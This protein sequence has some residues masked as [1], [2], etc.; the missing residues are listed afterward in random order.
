MATSGQK[1]VESL[2]IF[3]RAK[4]G[5]FAV[6]GQPAKVD[7][8]PV[9]SD[10]SRAVQAGVIDLCLGTVRLP[11]QFFNH[12]IGVFEC[13]N[14]VILVVTILKLIHQALKVR[15]LFGPN[16]V[17]SRYHLIA[18]GLNLRGQS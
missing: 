15:G 5:L 14:K 11:R 16:F 13:G 18:H 9:G 10:L 12:A 2:M 1:G 4:R 8:L 7:N 3:S 17:R 6:L